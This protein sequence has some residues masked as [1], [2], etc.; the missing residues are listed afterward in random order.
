M[1]VLGF[2]LFATAF[3]VAPAFGDE[4]SPVKKPAD[5]DKECCADQPLKIG[6]V[7]YAPKSVDVFRSLRYY[8]N[9]NG[10]PME[11]VLYSNYDDLN[12]ALS[13]RQVDLAWNSPL[14]HAKFHL[15]AGDSQAVVMRDVDR[16]YRV[17]LIVRK[18]ANVATLKDLGDKTMIF[19]SCDSADCTVLPVY[20]L[21]KG[22]QLRQSEDSQPP[23]RG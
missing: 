12:E 22:G 4:K 7:A 14:G 6:A 8:F 15:A 23:Q 1:R 5:K 11:F 21:E 17:K 3:L 20:F 10:M 2:V 18:D 19:G 16:D 9:K 13:K